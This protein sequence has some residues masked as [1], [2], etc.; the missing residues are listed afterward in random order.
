MCGESGVVFLFL[1]GPLLLQMDSIFFKENELTFFFRIYLCLGFLLIC[2]GSRQVYL[3]PDG[4]IFQ[5]AK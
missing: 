2:V 3:S 1:A 5:S 4:S